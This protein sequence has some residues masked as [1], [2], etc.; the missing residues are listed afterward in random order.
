MITATRLRELLDYDAATGAFRWRI[1]N[2]RRVKVG[3]LAGY[4]RSD[5]Y[6]MIR[7]DGAS[8]VGAHRLAWLWTHGE[9]PAKID[10]R[11]LDKANNR[12]GNLRP[13]TQSQNMANSAKGPRNRS[14]FKGVHFGRD[15]SRSKPWRASIRQ[16]WKLKHLGWFATPEEA[17]AAYVAAAKSVF[18]EFARAA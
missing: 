15:A 7:V 1:A 10:H 17:H 4:L 18:G 14:G 12:I 11:D 2:S 8:S 9:L 6:W 16:D 5:G 13:A 3:D